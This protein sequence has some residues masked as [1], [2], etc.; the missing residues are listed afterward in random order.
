MNLVNGNV[1]RL[2][3][4]FAEE[5]IRKTEK[6]W[7][8]MFTRLIKNDEANPNEIKSKVELLHVVLSTNDIIISPS[9]LNESK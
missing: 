3:A 7:K 4:G 1:S 2:G 9:T 6:Y 8:G 5:T